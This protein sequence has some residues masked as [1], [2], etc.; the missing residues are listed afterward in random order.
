[1]FCGGNDFQKSFLPEALAE[2][3]NKQ[4]IKLHSFY[5]L[6]FFSCCEAIDPASLFFIGF[7]YKN[8]RV[9]TGN[10]LAQ[11]ANVS[12]IPVRD[13]KFRDKRHEAIRQYF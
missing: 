9:L 4:N 8:S 6:L 11:L 12:E 1:M 3:F 10:H 13:K 7:T 5:R 2:F